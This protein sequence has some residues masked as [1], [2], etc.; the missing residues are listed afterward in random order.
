MLQNRCKVKKNIAK[1]LTEFAF[2]TLLTYYLSMRPDSGSWP[3]CGNNRYLP[4]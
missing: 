1:S 3:E 4:R 2:S